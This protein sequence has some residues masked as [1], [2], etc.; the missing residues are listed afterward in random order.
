ANHIASNFNLEGVRDPERL[1]YY[2]WPGNVRELHNWIER[3]SILDLYDDEGLIH[4]SLP[5]FGKD[6]E[7]KPQA[8]T[9]TSPKSAPALKLVSSTLVER[10][11][12]V[13]DHFESGWIQEALDKHDGN[14][15]AAARELGIDRKNLTRRIKDLGLKKAA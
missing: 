13:L 12:E 4:A 11:Q 2:A 14:I 3:A 7:A 6:I 5:H 15:S 10:R 9:T 8:E 1:R